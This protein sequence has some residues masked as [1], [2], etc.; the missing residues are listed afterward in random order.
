MA[1]QC[2]SFETKQ[3]SGNQLDCKIV[4]CPTME[5]SYL[6]DAGNSEQ[7]RAKLYIL[8]RNRNQYAMV[9]GFEL[10]NQNQYA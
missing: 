4:L 5:A 2:L 7:R 8:S 3:A 10:R 6:T 1:S 9:V